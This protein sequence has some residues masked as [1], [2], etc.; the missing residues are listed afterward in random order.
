ME[1]NKA[2]QFWLDFGKSVV[3]FDINAMLHGEETLSACVRRHTEKPW[4]KF[5]LIG[6]MGGL[7]VHFLLPP[8]NLERIFHEAD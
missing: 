7:A 3:D 4:Q 1:L 8:I 2:D 6:F 5:M